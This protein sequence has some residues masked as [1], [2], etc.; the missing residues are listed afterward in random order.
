MSL[1]S[2]ILKLESRL[3]KPTQLV[4]VAFQRAGEA[5]HELETNFNA[6]NPAVK[7]FLILVKFVD[8]NRKDD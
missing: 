3:S 1:N 7:V 4:K 2:R 6:K 5:N 8:S